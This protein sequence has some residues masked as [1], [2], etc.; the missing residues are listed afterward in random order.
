MRSNPKLFV[1]A[2]L[3]VLTFVLIAFYSAKSD[4]SERSRAEMSVSDPVEDKDLGR[5]REYKAWTIV[6]PEPVLMD[7]Q[8]A[9]LCAAVTVT[10]FQPSPHSHKYISVFVNS[11][12]RESMLT[13]REPVFPVGSMI[14]KEKLSSKDSKSPELLTAMIKHEKGYYPEGGDWEYLLLDGAATKIV[15][16]GK[17]QQCNACHQL[18]KGRDFVTR[19]YLPRNVANDLK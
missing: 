11:V 9:A 13:K 5:L 7:Q 1:V 8:T 15:E 16:R 2:V 10:Q 14:L 12:G 18:Y 6:N 17:L 4:I 3:P 19:T